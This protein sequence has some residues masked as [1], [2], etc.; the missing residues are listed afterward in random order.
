MLSH[1]ITVVIPT[2]SP[3]K[4]LLNR[5]LESVVG[6]LYPA[7]AIVVRD[8]VYR[9]GAAW[10]RHVGLL[11]VDTEWVAFLDDDDVLWPQHLEVL[12]N[13][14]RET[15]ADYLFTWYQIVDT[16]GN[17]QRDTVLGHFGKVFNPADPH[18]TTITTM[19]RTELAKSVGFLGDAGTH[20]I[21]GQRAGEDFAFTL[22]CIRKGAKIVH[23]PE[24]TWEWHHHGFNTSGLPNRW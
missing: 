17:H 18:Q 22:G 21:H 3:R 15:G 6:Q 16:E 5:A 11:Q 19:V 1:D 23:V 2:I 24:I 20:E 9:R 4:L 14:Q 10:N 7:T 12:V 8:D 13:A